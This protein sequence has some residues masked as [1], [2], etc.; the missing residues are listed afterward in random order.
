M[1]FLHQITYR[2]TPRAV[3]TLALELTRLQALSLP[4]VLWG[5]LVFV[6]TAAVG[7]REETINSGFVLFSVALPGLI[8]ALALPG[9][10]FFLHYR[11]FTALGDRVGAITYELYE[12]GIITKTARGES[13]TAYELYDGYTRTHSGYLLRL[14]GTGLF[15]IPATSADTDLSRLIEAK[16]T[17]VKRSRTWPL[18]PWIAGVL[19]ALAFGAGYLYSGKK[20]VAAPILL[21][22]NL[23]FVLTLVYYQTWSFGNWRL[24][25]AYGLIAL[26]L[27]L[28]AYFEARA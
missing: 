18:H 26:A 16:L 7:L 24:D 28:D 5:V 6:L 21:T 3:T 25:L 11:R 2:L 23:F 12:D 20:A 27:G 17:E 10:L 13:R 14:A 9:L 8:L 1:P 4:V 15:F 19:N 22:A